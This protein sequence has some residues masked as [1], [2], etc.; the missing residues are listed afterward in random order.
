MQEALPY[1]SPRHVSIARNA[2]CSRMARWIEALRGRSVLLAISAQ[3]LRLY[4]LSFHPTTPFPLVFL[5][6]RDERKIARE[7]TLPGDATES[8][9]VPGSRP[10]RATT[11]LSQEMVSLSISDLDENAFPDLARASESAVSVS[12]NKGGSNCQ[13][14]AVRLSGVGSSPRAGYGSGGRG[15]PRN[16]KLSE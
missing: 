10:P 14:Q 15:P 16:R 3:D 2:T 4:G 7:N 12:L 1:R 5:A 11:N 8:R 9:T 13:S 6:R